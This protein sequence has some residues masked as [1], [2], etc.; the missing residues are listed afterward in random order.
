MIN[1]EISLK[2]VVNNTPKEISVNDLIDLD[3]DNED[4]Y[5]YERRCRRQ[6]SIWNE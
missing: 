3:Q 1:K 4:R 6:E 2:R 5:I